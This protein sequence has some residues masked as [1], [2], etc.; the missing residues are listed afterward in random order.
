MKKNSSHILCETFTLSLFLY[1]IFINKTKKVYLID[2]VDFY[3]NNT[4]DIS[5]LEKLF[6]FLRSDIEIIRIPKF[7]S[8]NKSNKDLCWE[9]NKKALAYFESEIFFR[10]LNKIKPILQ[11]VMEDTAIELTIKKLYLPY[12]YRKILFLTAEKELRDS[13]PSTIKVFETQPDFLE[14]KDY[15]GHEI[16]N[17]RFIFKLSSIRDFFKTIFFLLFSPFLI[18]DI[19]KRGLC[20]RR[21]KL[22]YFDLAI[23]L[24]WG[25][26][27][28]SYLK[29]N[30]YDDE[31]VKSNNISPENILF[32]EKNAHGRNISKKEYEEQVKFSK[33][34]GTGIVRESNLK[35]PVHFFF[36]R[37]L[38]FGSLISSLKM[39]KLF[40]SKKILFTELKEVQRII[41]FFLLHD[42]FCNYFRVKVFVSRDDYSFEHIVRT[43][44]QNKYGLFNVG[45]QHSNFMKPKYLPHGAWPYFDRYYTQ[46]DG[47]VDLWFPYFSYNKTLLPIGTQRDFSILEA[48]NNKKISEQFKK[49][50]AGS[51]NLLMNISP[52]SST[53]SP[54][55]LIRKKYNDFW[56]LLE[57]N[58]NLKIILRPRNVD[59]EKSFLNFFPQI[60][61][62][63]DKGKIV[64][65]HTEFT[66]Q[67]LIAYC[68]IFISEDSSSTILEAAHF[69]HI[70][71]LSLNMRY[72]MNTLLKGVLYENFDEICNQV[73]LYLVNNEIP[74]ANKETFKKLRSLYS[75]PPGK[76]AFERL[77]EDIAS[78][79]I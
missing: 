4:F 40:F 55:W 69:E 76:S 47:F 45:M 72:P 26:P 16:F 10:L 5:F 70:Y 36:T 41:S 17:N 30:V 63:V 2:S 33:E 54:D 58:R 56:K 67:E 43:N 1:L 68:D 46:G 71:I 12:A 32:I 59:A 31:F 65:E 21:D 48:L 78:S 27:G 61:E 28:S 52:P 14:M 51:I 77:T 74:N 38:L 57:L 25:F 24:V 8:S 42:L 62:Y 39:A 53:Y 75:L 19:L 49:K 15:L 37:Y 9:A 18:R 20:I 11:K 66:T 23:P 73:K 6:V 64:F 3:D 79:F 35:V 29:S 50:Y 22:R 13:S 60:K 34:I 44:V 7:V